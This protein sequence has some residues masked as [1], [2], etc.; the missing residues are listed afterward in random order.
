MAVNT[1]RVP[2]VSKKPFKIESNK[3]VPKNVSSGIQTLREIAA[4]YEK[5]RK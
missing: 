5:K 3:P 1:C 4:S 2:P